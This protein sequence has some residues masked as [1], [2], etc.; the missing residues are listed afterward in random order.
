MTNLPTLRRLSRSP[1]FTALTGRVLT[2]AGIDANSKAIHI[3]ISHR[4]SHNHVA[5][6]SG[7]DLSRFLSS[8]GPRT[9]HLCTLYSSVC[10]PVIRRRRLTVIRVLELSCPYDVRSHS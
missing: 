3:P 10:A 1:F 2:S 8:G 6:H 9:S 5:S 7:T 4:R